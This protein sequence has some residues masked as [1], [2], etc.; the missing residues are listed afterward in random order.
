MQYR[1]HIN[2]TNHLGQKS[3]DLRPFPLSPSRK[4][5]NV[6]RKLQLLLEGGRKAYR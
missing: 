5:L 6:N 1:I 2:T 3:S 4:R